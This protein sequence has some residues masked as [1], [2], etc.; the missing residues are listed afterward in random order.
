[1]HQSTVYLHN[2]NGETLDSVAVT[3]N[4]YGSFSGS[5]LLPRGLLNGNFKAS[6]D[7]TDTL[8]QGITGALGDLVKQLLDEAAKAAAT[9]VIALVT[10]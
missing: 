8:A 5:F 2:A 1:M 10:A 7:G 9:A 6:I 3:T 4:S